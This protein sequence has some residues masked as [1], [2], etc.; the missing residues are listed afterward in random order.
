MSAHSERS[1]EERLARPDY[2]TVLAAPRVTAKTLAS[3]PI[4]FSPDSKHRRTER[5]L[6]AF[7]HGGT[8]EDLFSGGLT[9]LGDQSAAEVLLKRLMRPRRPLPQDPVCVIR[10]VFDLHTGHGA[11][12]APV[13]PEC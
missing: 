10:D 7:A 8:F 13:A 1:F 6:S 2:R 4:T 5:H 3:T 9:R 12:L 11:I